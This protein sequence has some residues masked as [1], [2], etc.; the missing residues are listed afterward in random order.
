VALTGDHMGNGLMRD[1]NELNKYRITDPSTWAGDGT[2]GAFLIPSQLK[3]RP[4]RVI[5]S[6][7][8]VWDH[9][10]VSLEHRIPYWSE[11]SMIH[12]MFFKEDE[13]AMQLHVPVSEHINNHPHVLHL[14][15]SHTQPIPMPPRHMV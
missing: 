12:R 4:L 14:W 2:C 8:E 13:V 3:G 9:V 5:A 7:D 1:L 10:S 11:M 6:A 15:R